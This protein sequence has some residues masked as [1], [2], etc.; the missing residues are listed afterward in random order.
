MISY[1]ITN[2]KEECYGCRACEQICP[3]HAISMETDNEGFLYPTLNNNLCINC[4][5]CEQVCPFMNSQS[6]KE[7]IHWYASWAKDKQII[8]K[9]ST[10]G[11]FALIAEYVLENK[12]IVIGCTINYKEKKAQHVIIDKHKDIHCLQGSKYMQS[13]TLN[14]FTL[15]KK[16]LK[17][18]KLVYYTGTPCQI[19]GLRNY[20]I[21]DYANLITS[22]LICHGVCSNLFFQKEVEYWQNKLKGTITNFRCR[23]K[24]KYKWSDG[25]VIAFDLIKKNGKIKTYDIPA[26]KSI[27]Y[28]AFAYADKAYNHRISCYNCLYKSS[29]RTGDITIGDFWGF[30]KF[31]KELATPE[32]YRDGIALVAINTIKGNNFFSCILDKIQFKEI[33]KDKA[34]LQEALISNKTKKEIPTLRYTL[35]KKILE[36]DYRM[37]AKKYLFTSN[38]Y[39]QVTKMNINRFKRTIKEIIKK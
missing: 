21:K 37:M 28:Y 18:N 23:S 10:A 38:Y 24:R 7:P 11:I 16:A 36:M 3:R 12:G 1:I 25:G 9:S 35:Y 8:K 39:I 22:D 26:I 4:T 5:L 31:Y 29:Y 19:A 2:N 34:I 27:M 32:R 14:T 20:L 6:K 13:D 15:V 33:E 17:E 30:E